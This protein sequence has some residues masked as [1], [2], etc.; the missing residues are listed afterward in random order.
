MHMPHTYSPR[1]NRHRTSYMQSNVTDTAD[2]DSLV[3]V[4]LS[5]GLPELDIELE[6]ETRVVKSSATPCFNE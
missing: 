1:P 2:G 6:K 3:V 4:G 5:T